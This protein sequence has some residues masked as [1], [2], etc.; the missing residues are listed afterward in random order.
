RSPRTDPA[1]VRDVAPV[2][3]LAMCLLTLVSSG[4]EKAI[5]FAPAEVD[6]LFPGPFTRRQLLAYKIGKSLAGV[7]FSSLLLSIVFLQHASGWFQ[8]W[9]A[10]F[11]ALLFV[12]LLGMGITLIS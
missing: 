10:V 12:Q 5:A 11:L 2:I 8:G 7:A 4:G 6:F 1:A 9:S 3:L